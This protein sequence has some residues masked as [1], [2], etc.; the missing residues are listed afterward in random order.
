LRKLFATNQTLIF[1]KRKFLTFLN[2]YDRCQ[3]VFSKE[4]DREQKF[5]ILNLFNDVKQVK[6]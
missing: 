6:K 4:Q 5:Y 2:A 3:S 1:E